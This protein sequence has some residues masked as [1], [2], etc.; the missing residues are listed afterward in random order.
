MSIAG[1]ISS[2]D[3]GAMI[4]G[5][6]NAIVEAQAK[7]AMTTVDFVRNVGFESTESPGG[8]GKARM[9]EFEYTRNVYD[10][11]TNETTEVPTTVKLPL[12][13]LLPIPFI[14]VDYGEIDFNV[15]ITSMD[16]SQ[17]SEDTS[18]S[19]T[20]DVEFNYFC[21]SAKMSVSASYQ[22]K[23]SSESQM[24]KTYQLGVKVRVVQDDLPAGMERVLGLLEDGLV[25]APSSKAA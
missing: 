22:K 20:L 23:T 19:G 15:K 4:G 9:V 7:S 12:L 6:L 5:P 24:E 18:A 3:F 8:F 13:V 2:I 14:R 1:E 17:T 21:V 11:D 25:I 10:P 16:R